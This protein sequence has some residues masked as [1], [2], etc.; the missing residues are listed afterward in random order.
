MSNVMMVAPVNLV[1]DALFFD[2]VTGEVWVKRIKKN[3][4]VKKS[5]IGR[6]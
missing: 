4:P 1:T 3:T 2:V 5:L 6:T